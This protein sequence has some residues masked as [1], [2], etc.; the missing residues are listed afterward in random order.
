MTGLRE[1]NG[2]RYVPARLV[3]QKHPLRDPNLAW[4]S[5]ETTCR[6]VCRFYGVRD[7]ERAYELA[8]REIADACSEDEFGLTEYESLR[9]WHEAR[10]LS[11]RYGAV[12][13]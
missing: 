4:W 7:A 13:A 2:N 11:L 3:T 1:R 10:V 6:N 9:D 12:P 8:R 5:Y